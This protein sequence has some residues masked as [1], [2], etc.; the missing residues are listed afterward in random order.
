MDL[1]EYIS[2]SLLVLLPIL[3]AC[4]GALKKSKLADWKIPFVLGGAGIAFACI[5]LLAENYPAGIHDLLKALLAGFSQGLICA[6][7]TVYAHNLVTQY[8]NKDG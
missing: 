3:Y 5:W 8:K 1:N 7:V 4:G 2:P 6:A